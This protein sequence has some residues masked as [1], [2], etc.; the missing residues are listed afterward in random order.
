[1]SAPAPERSYVRKV[2]RPEMT[3]RQIAADFPSSRAVFRSYGEPDDRPGYFGHLEPLTHFARRRGLALETLLNELMEVTDVPIELHGPLAEQVHRPFILAALAV[4]LSLGAGWGGW[5]LW[6]IGVSQDFGA[7]PAAQVIAHGE[8]QLWGF[9]VPFVMGISLRTV[10]QAIARHPRGAAVCRGLLVSLFA[11]VVGSFL[12]FLAPSS[13]P[14]LGVISALLLLLTAVAYWMIQF[15]VLG[16]KVFATWSRAV[17]LS[18]F[19]LVVWASVT[20]TLRIAA[21]DEGP[22]VYLRAHRILIIELAVFGFAMNSIYGFGQ[23]LLPGLLRLG[24]PKHLALALALWLHNLGTATICLTTAQVWPDS[25]AVFGS[26]LIAAGALTY[27][28]GQ[29]AFLGRARQSDRAEQGQPL[30]DIYVPLAFF[31]LI[32]SLL[33]LTAGHAQQA[34]S[35]VVM[36]HAYVGALRHALTVGF[37]TTL[38]LGVGQRM[39]PV[40]EHKVLALPGLVLPILV[41]IGIGNLI[42]VSSEL[43]A[44]AWPTAHRVMPVSALVEWMALA[45]FTVNTVAT[46][47]FI[48]P[49]LVSDRVTGMSSLAVLLAERPWIEDWLIGSGCDYL[50]RVRCVPHELTLAGFAKSDDRAPDHFVAEINNVLL[51]NDR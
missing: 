49:L 26:A 44:M 11:G 12:W 35:G 1:M 9:I 34:S 17:I 8:A 46:I 3:V 21:A 15:L 50:T 19:W 41:L 31:W 22:G 7:V 37:M 14:M 18:G 42:R 30:L 28:C 23:M 33:M 36:T 25:L 38:I 10:L 32:V 40:L 20:L 27:A 16:S 45:L 39:L 51:L 29:K 24:Q 5:L 2:I 13:A 47:R 4:T 48:D 6:R 43:G